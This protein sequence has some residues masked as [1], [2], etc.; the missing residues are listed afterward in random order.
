MKKRNTRILALLLA[1]MMV[2]SVLSACKSDSADGDTT[3]PDAVTTPSDTGAADTGAPP[4]EPTGA[5]PVVS[6]AA[7]GVPKYIFLF[8]G[9]GMS[10][11]QLSALGYYNGTLEHE[12][13]GTLKEPTPD[14]I[15]QAEMPSFMSFPIVGACTTYDASKFVTDSASAATAIATGTKTLDGIISQDVNNNDVPTIAELV[16]DQLGYKVGIV[17]TASLDHATPAAF[18]AHSSSRNFYYDIALSAFETDF[19]YFGG[20]GFWYPYGPE[21]DVEKSLY[22]LAVDAGFTFANTIED[23]N[24]LDSNSGAQ[25]L[26]VNPV[27]DAVSSVPYAIDRDDSVSLELADFVRKGIDVL[28]NDTGFFMMVESGKIDW[29]G[30][31][32]DALTDIMEIKELEKAVNEA[33][34]F[35]DLHPDETLIIITGDHE[36]GGFSNGYQGTEYDTYF[37]VLSTQTISSAAYTDIVNTYIDNG[38]TYEE[39]MADVKEYFGLILPEDPDA[40]L[41]ENARHVLTEKDVQMFKDAYEMTMTPPADRPIKD[42]EYRTLYGTYYAQPIVITAT[43]ILNNKAGIGWSTTS[44]SALPAAVFAKGAGQDAFS[45]FYDNTD[46][47]NKLVDMLGITK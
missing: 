41:E 23:I 33:V 40:A 30:H 20:G 46:I 37:S 36:T 21:G 14:N 44:H 25:V 22:E 29:A 39:A 31:A 3:S 10:F 24:A 18:Y 6:T 47:F 38:T 8:I 34:K 1:L 42:Q 45:G 32:N 13:V 11:P 4:A 28:E 27:L 9:D 5:A 19:E 12:F 26:A 35:A 16:H 43:H 17:S 15:P 2:A 7:A